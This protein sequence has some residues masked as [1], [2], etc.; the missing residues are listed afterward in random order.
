MNTIIRFLLT[1]CI[2]ILLFN[3]NTGKKPTHKPKLESPLTNFLES[4]KVKKGKKIKKPSSKIDKS[5]I[6]TTDIASVKQ[7]INTIKSILKSI[8]V[9]GAKK[10][11]R[12]KK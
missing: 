2:S 10:D 1:S 6:T 8:E 4:T 5:S 7:D 9:G 12:E 11:D 3:C